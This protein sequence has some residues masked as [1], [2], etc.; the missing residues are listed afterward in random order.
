[1]STEA[2]VQSRGLKSLSQRGFYSETLHHLRSYANIRYQE[3][4]QFVKRR[5]RHPRESF[6]KT[7]SEIDSWTSNVLSDWKIVANNNDFRVRIVSPRSTFE[8]AS[9]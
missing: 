9:S 5:W 4:E 6:T 8:I 7:F 3:T 1:M 2:G